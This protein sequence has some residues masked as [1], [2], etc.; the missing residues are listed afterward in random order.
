M[1]SEFWKE[2]WE[3]NQIGFHLDEVNPMLEKHFHELGLKEGSS[4]F[5]PL[6]GKTLDIQWLL[7]K[8]YNIVGAELSELA[9][10]QLFEEL[11]VKPDV[12]TQKKFKVYQTKNLK[13]FVGDI[14][15]LS[16]ELLVDIDGVYDR[17]ALVALPFNI[18]EKYT[19]HLCNISQHLPQLLLN[20]TYDQSLMNGPPFSVTGEEIK[21]HYSKS[22]EIILLESKEVEGK[23][24]GKV[25]AEEMA[26]LLK[27]TTL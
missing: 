26:W 25:Y 20:F 24:K 15:D 10:E 8:G 1:D 21:E 14:F 22:Y 19:A 4:I 2:R 6:C 23:F 18:R 16:S 11:R 5:I 7:S 27:K 12:S 3:K 17:A 13:I 9:I